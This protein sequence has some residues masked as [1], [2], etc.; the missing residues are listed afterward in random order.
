MKHGA[1]WARW[2][3]LAAGVMLAG[4]LAW[5]WWPRGPQPVQAS[6]VA[7]A[8]PQDTAGYAQ[9]LGPRPLVFPADHG[10]HDDYQTEWWYYTGNLTASTGEHFGFELTFFRRALQPPSARVA[11]TSDLATDQVFLADFALTDVSGGRHDVVERLERGAGGLAGAQA[12]PYR[13]WLDDWSV[14]GAPGGQLRLR[15]AAGDV[16]LALALHDTKGP[17]L[18]GDRGYSRKGAQAGNASYYYSLT[19][20]TTAGEVTARG[21]TFAVSGLGWMDHE[22][23]T[24]ALEP[25]L[26][27]WDWFSLQL[28]DGS[29]VMLYGLRR[30]DGTF[31]PFSSG[32]LVAP[33]GTTRHLSA[34]DFAFQAT[35]HWRSPHTGA[36]Y[37]AGWTV[38]VPQANLRLSVTPY[39]ADQEMAVSLPYWEGA[40]RVQGS[41]GGRPVTGDGYVEL[42]GY[43]ASLGGRF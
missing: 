12:E 31:G 34:Q 20:L 30:A 22:F 17:V 10:P 9:V 25:G 41:V 16:A 21:R 5:A 18:Q 1:K 27:G 14:D 43:A 40:T 13:V 7:A 4:G 19:R 23:S 32:T 29:E 26:V 38:E 28:S 2:L 15:A 33:D 39:L 42:T 24:S 37:P 8:P 11:R 35:G 3:P 36:V 6:L